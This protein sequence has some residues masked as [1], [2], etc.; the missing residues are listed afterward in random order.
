MRLVGRI[1][2]LMTMFFLVAFPC[3]KLV[4]EVEKKNFVL[5]H[6]WLKLS[7]QPKWK[8]FIVNTIKTANISTEEEGGDSSDPTKELPKNV[9]RG[10]RG[11][12][13][14]KDKEKREGAAAKM[15]E[16]LENILAKKETYVKRFESRKKK[17]S[18][19]FKC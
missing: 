13:W 10:F 6:C 12:K 5:K 17:M 7:G 19:R 4:L 18:E 11:K 3:V 1:Y 14:E 2:N 8:L 15:T 9:R 16:R